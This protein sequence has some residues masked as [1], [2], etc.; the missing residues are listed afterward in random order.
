MKTRIIA[1]LCVAVVP[2][3]CATPAPPPQVEAWLASGRG[4]PPPQNTCPAVADL[5]LV[6]IEAADRAYAASRPPRPPEASF[7]DLPASAE[8]LIPANAQVVI[9]TNLPPGGLYRNDLR[10]A[11]WKTA[12]GEWRVWRQ[13]KN[14]GAEEPNHWPPAPAGTPAYEA[15][16]AERRRPKTDEERWPPETGP[17]AAE[18]VAR[19]EAALADPCRAWDPDVFP[20]EQPLLRR[21]EY[22]ED[23]RICPPDGGVYLADITEPGRPRRGIGASCINDTP[24][25][26][27]ISAAA[28]AAPQS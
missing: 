27:L 16:D 8:A 14:Y 5:D 23:R 21:N 3:G 10:S 19:L 15:W 12:D 9:R 2:A 6:A 24:T 17:L 1:A 4:E 13:N 26:Q 11:V 25:F 28:Y 7:I 22:G 18:V 20:W